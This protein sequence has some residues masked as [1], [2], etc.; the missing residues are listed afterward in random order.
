M[1]AWPSAR[2]LVFALTVG[3][4]L[5][6]A[7]TA[8]AQNGVIVDADGVLRMKTV[9]DP[10]GVLHRQRLAQAMA[11]LN[12]DLAVPSDLRKLSLNRLEAELAARI[13]DGLGPTDEMQN[14]AGL[15]QIRYV[16]FYP[17]TND[18][19]IAGPAEG[20]FADAS[21]RMVGIDSGRAVL[22]LEDLVVALRAF[23]PGHEGAKT[24]SVSIDPSQEGLQRMQQFLLRVGGRATPRDTAAL[25]NGLKESLGEQS[26]NFRGVSPKTH[27]AQ[28]LAEADYRM[29]LI[30]IGLE[31]PPVKIT[32]Y[33]SRANPASVARNALQRWYFKPNYECV[34]VSKDELAM[35]LVGDGVK[36]VG[37]DELVT[38][39]GGRVGSGKV[40]SASQ[41]F[42]ESF[43]RLYP[44]LAEKSPVYG[45]L[46][47]LIDMSIVAAFIQKYDY[48]GQASWKMDFFGS[49]EAY[50]VE[51]YNAPE[52]VETAVNAIWKGRTLMT[53]IGGGVNIQAR[54]ALNRDRLLADEDGAVKATR[55]QIDAKAIPADR[56][57]WD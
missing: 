6:A 31:E 52:K 10:S 37:A 45:Q 56:W 27:F 19:V 18:I 8:S 9:H 4:A 42:V 1:L 12:K 30:G 16:F 2:I 26:V 29:K 5:L 38:A 44:Q 25:V 51:T 32:S 20:Y 47:N 15:T 48:Y 13:R 53:P 7:A 54:V 28:V 57:W 23:P 49:E 17:E 22:Q 41:Q 39:D 14:L 40:D 55:S 34:K 33:V 35:Q 50:P 24:I 43:T 36:L 11:S 21:G 3:S 46:R